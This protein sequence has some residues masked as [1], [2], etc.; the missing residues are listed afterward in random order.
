[1]QLH[2]FA[3]PGR[4]YKGNLHL[5]STKS[6]GTLT[7]ADVIDAYR[8]RGY[9]FV[10]LTDHFLPETHFRPDA[11]AENFIR[12]TDTADYRTDTF[13]TIPGAELHG[14][15][16]E[17]GEAWHIVANGL[18]L[19]FPVPQANET[20]L[21]IA[22]RARSAGAYISLAHPAWNSVSMNDGLAAAD[23]VNAVE[24]YNHSCSV[25]VQRDNGWYLLDYLL[26][27][28]HRLDANAA[29]DAH[30]KREHA[31]DAFGGWVHVK[32]ESLE[33]EALV[34]ALK[35]GDYYSS[36]GQQI[37]DIQ[38]EQNHV[39][40]RCS[41]ATAIVLTGNGAR[42]VQLTGHDLIHAELDLEKFR[43]HG[44]FR[45]TVVAADRTAAWSNP[46]WLD[47]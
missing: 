3:N 5:H 4:F 15:A 32:S 13:T 39:I 30:F 7:P 23:I 34:A 25:V 46:I 16:M 22:R 1:M 20:G 10:S 2:P 41:P 11:P 42:S 44:W 9:D 28:G 17:N 47:S 8:T 31:A 19:D 18:P 37:L 26:Q 43:E 12:I 14:P 6:D 24:I 29:D 40:V 21:D 35:R 45:I 27:Q 36:S 33:P 38:L